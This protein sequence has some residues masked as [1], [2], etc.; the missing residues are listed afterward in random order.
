QVACPRKAATSRSTPRRARLLP[1][2][3]ALVKLPRETPRRPRM[4]QVAHP[5]ADSA[6]G[7]RLDR[8]RFYLARAAESLQPRFMA[9]ETALLAEVPLFQL[10]DDNERAELAAHLEVVR[11]P[12]GH[13]V[14]E[15]GDA[16][17]TIYIIRD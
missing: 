9:P 16:G 12:A 10:L 11:H 6:A 5:S 4:A 7:K 15:Y 13:V 1:S 8:P 3:R 17:D 14:F 2:V